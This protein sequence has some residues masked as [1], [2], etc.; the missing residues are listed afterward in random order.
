MFVVKIGDDAIRHM[1]VRNL[2]IPPSFMTGILTL[3]IYVLK[4]VMRT[5]RR[6]TAGERPWSVSGISQLAN[7]T[8]QAG[9]E[10]LAQFSISE[11]ALHQMLTATPPTGKSNSGANLSSSTI[12]ETTLL[13]AELSNSHTG[14]L[15]RRK[16]RLRKRTL[17]IIT[18]LICTFR[19]P[20]K[21]VS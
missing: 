11:S 1:F 14:S 17:V 8:P 13:A 3:C 9:R 10:P 19:T 18:L 2:V 12:D 7:S 21:I 16:T 5:K 15:R 4:V 6:Q 20:S